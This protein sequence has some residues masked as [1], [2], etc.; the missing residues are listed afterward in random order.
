LRGMNFG[1]YQM[2]AAFHGMGSKDG[3]VRRRREGPK[4]GGARG[5]RGGGARARDIARGGGARR[6]QQRIRADCV[7]GRGDETR[8]HETRSRGFGAK[9]KIA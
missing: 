8:S 1:A 2:V 4:G 9:C 7:D 5:A 3:R 6:S